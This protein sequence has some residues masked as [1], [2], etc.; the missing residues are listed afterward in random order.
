M[1]H[2][3]TQITAMEGISRLAFCIGQELAQNSRSGLTVRFLSKKLELPEEEIE[4]LVDVNPNLFFFD[5][6]KVKLVAEGAA[7]VKRIS[8]G[9]EN[10]GDVQSMYQYI[11][12]M[13]PHDFRRLEERIGVDKPGGKKAAV[14]AMVD[15]HYSHPDSIV[16]YVAT[17]GFSARAQEVFDLI[18]QANDSVMPV[19]ALRALHSE[20]E[21]SVEQALWEL[22]QGLAVFEMFRFD[23]E[24]RLVRV[25]GLMSEIRQW[26][27]NSGSSRKKSASL[28]PFR[29]TPE[30]I[31]SRGLDLSE[32]VG[33]LVSAVAARP[34]R[35]RG[36]GDLF[37]E[38][39]RRLSEISP[40]DSE[41]V[42]DTLLWIAE[43]V[44]WLAR[45]DNELR[46]G[47]LEALIRLDRLSRH[48]KLFDWMARSASEV[49]S[50]RV[51]TK[52]L[53][54]LEPDVWYPVLPFIEF[55]V[56][57]SEENEQPVLK[58]TGG[59]WQYMSPST[60]AG[61][62]RALARSLEETFLWLG[63]VDRAMHKGENCFRLAA[64]GNYLLTGE[65]REKVASHFPERLTEIVV[66]PNFDIVVPAQEG[67][68]LL[69]VP[70]E[71]F[72][73]RQSVGQAIVYN[74]NKD[75]FTRG[76]QEGHD[77]AGFV[78]FLLN[79]NRGGSLPTNVLQTLE[80]W[81]GGMK[82]VRLRTIHVLEAEDPLVIADLLH[83]RRF[84]K[85]LTA[86]DGRKVVAYTR[87]SKAELVKTLEKEGFI[88][89]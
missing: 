46:A 6:T 73:D 69:A 60:S 57:D 22:I 14:E 62:E 3:A 54:D 26:R 17:R 4:Y 71:Q 21:Y 20:P 12:G 16:E 36:D 83:R 61:F 58:N 51:M 43:G 45:V 33:R 52:L 23:Q 64:L 15:N 8:M 32:R 76:V 68:P 13:S 2:G 78:D 37:R 82:H 18:W 89:G 47:E 75:S 40:E 41:P 66:Q 11:K 31:E 72:A 38:D 85:H 84:A 30:R 35:L 28:K 7:A 48:R 88:V 86:V 24:E 34:V 29:G 19:S 44:G 67:D 25:V 81:R 70:L 77:G 56:R 65:G 39:R 27:E 55:A 74:L 1:R 50:R 87:I 53:E 42:L 63:V 5:L 10:L 9:L 79:H 49:T 80:D 59:Y